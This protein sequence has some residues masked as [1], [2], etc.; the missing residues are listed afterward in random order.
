M[1]VL[2]VRNGIRTK[3]ERGQTLLLVS[4]VFDYLAIK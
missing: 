2:I 4:E 1:F 3:K